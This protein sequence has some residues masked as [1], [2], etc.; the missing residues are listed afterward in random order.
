MSL[1]DKHN[2]D[3]YK[4]DG[5][6]RRLTP[7]ECERLQGFTPIEKYVSIRICL[8]HLKNFVSAEIKSLKSQSSVGSA[9]K[10]ELTEFARFAENALKQSDQNDNDVAPKD[11][12]MSCEDIT[13]HAIIQRK[14]FCVANTVGKIDLFP[15]A[16]LQDDFALMLV[17]INSTLES[18][19]RL[20]GEGLLQ[21]GQCLTLQKNGVWLLDLSGEEIMRLVEDAVRDLITRREPLK[22]IISNLFNTESS[23]QKLITLSCFATLAIVGFIPVKTSARNISTVTFTT[24]FGWT[25]FGVDGPVSDSQRYKCLGNSVTTNVI[26]AIM[27]RIKEIL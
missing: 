2:W 26:Q 17:G 13:T 21:N 22:S 15:H 4:V 20:G 7:T 9:A 11:V 24:R 3:T 16:N 23:E 12:L 25:R 1:T 10:T 19:I 27:S 18:V 14:S 8:D 6:I 5:R